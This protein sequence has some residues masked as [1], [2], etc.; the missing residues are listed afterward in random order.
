MKVIAEVKP[1]THRI[2]SIL[3]T[4]SGAMDFLNNKKEVIKNNLKTDWTLSEEAD[5][6]TVRDSNGTEL[7]MYIS[8]D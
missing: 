6:F 2:T 7:R 3:P 8:Q 1:G 5:G 4:R